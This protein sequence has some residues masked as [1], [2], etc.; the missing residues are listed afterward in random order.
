VAI[1]LVFE[2]CLW[3]GAGRCNRAGTFVDSA[4]LSTGGTAFS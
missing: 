1:A 4:S 2:I 3:R